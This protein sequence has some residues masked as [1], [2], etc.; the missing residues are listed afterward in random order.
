MS[1]RLIHLPLLMAL[2]VAGCEADD[3]SQQDPEREVLRLEELTG[4]DYQ[5]YTLAVSDGCLDGAL[6]ALFMPAGPATRHAFEYPVYLPSADEL[7]I[8]YSVDFRE[9]FM[10]MDV[11]V[12]RLDDSTLDVDGSTMQAVALGG[13]SGDCVADM[14]ADAEIW[15]VASDEVEG[16]A[17]IEVRD[18]RGDDE[19][20]P[21]FDA[22]PCQV[23]LTLA[24]EL[25]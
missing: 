4:G 5:F 25:D 19:L 9:P 13:T 2:L 14:E 15:P 24:A 22:D 21:V 12:D 10:G 18:P 16:A 17:V 7:P 6:E 11:T 3:D 23:A 8:S 20:C 1:A